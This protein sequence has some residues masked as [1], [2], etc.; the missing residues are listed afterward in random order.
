MSESSRCFTMSRCARFFFVSFSAIFLV[1]SHCSGI[2]N[3]YYSAHGPDYG[4]WP[5]ERVE[6]AF[7]HDIKRLCCNGCNRIKSLLIAEWEAPSH[8]IDTIDADQRV[9]QWCNGIRNRCEHW[10]C[11]SFRTYRM[12]M[13]FDFKWFHRWFISSRRRC[14]MTASSCDVSDPNNFRPVPSS[15]S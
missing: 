14:N 13:L 15:R 8:W 5:G 1:F 4:H 2:P 6:C 7:K 10:Q 12:A 3:E 11:D 9:Q